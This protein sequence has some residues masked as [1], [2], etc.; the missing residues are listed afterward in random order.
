MHGKSQ[1]INKKEPVE[2]YSCLHSEGIKHLKIKENLQSIS[3]RISF[4]DQPRQ[5][6]SFLIYPQL[7]VENM[8]S[9]LYINLFQASERFICTIANKIS[10]FIRY[11]K[12]PQF[13]MYQNSEISFPFISTA[14]SFSVGLFLEKLVCKQNLIYPIS[15]ATILSRVV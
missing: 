1:I 6:P 9:C 10:T 14:I 7:V 11:P 4:V 8:N 15:K 12:L 2:S 5:E 13:T 3:E